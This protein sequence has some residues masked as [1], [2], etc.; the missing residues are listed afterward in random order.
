MAPGPT[1]SGVALSSI[2]TGLT[3]SFLNVIVSVLVP[4]LSRSSVAVKVMTMSLASAVVLTPSSLMVMIAL[5][6]PAP[7]AL[8][9]G[10]QRH[11]VSLL[12]IQRGHI[13]GDRHYLNIR[14]IRR[15]R[16]GGG[17][18]D[19]HLKLPPR[20]QASAEAA[21]T[22]GGPLVLDNPNLQGVVRAAA[23]LKADGQSCVFLRCRRNS[24]R[25]RVFLIAIVISIADWVKR[26]GRS[27]LVAF[28]VK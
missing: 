12:G 20:P 14:R 25:T 9:G 16:G 11:G 6:V 13:R 19:R 23:N 10:C 21:L 1:I 15:D 22:V 8:P 27:N 5:H 17:L 18:P 2:S 4:L 3:Q 7:S 26:F 24:D 28:G